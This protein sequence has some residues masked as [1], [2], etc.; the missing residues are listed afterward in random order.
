VAEN[1]NPY[2]KEDPPI[3]T[4]TVE[5]KPSN[6]KFYLKDQA[7]MSHM[8]RML[9]QEK[10]KVKRNK[11]AADMARETSGSAAAGGKGS[12]IKSTRTLNAQTAQE[13]IERIHKI[14]EDE[15]GEN[16]E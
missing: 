1:T 3:Y 7:E 6:A 16:N 8:L 2:L 15:G 11:S 13:L 14:K 9:N 4:C 10:W 5:K 12:E